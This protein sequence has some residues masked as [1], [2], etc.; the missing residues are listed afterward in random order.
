[1]F[2]AICGTTGRYTEAPG[3][4][5]FLE[6]FQLCVC[7]LHVVTAMSRHIVRDQLIRVS[8]EDTY[9]SLFLHT[10]GP[11]STSLSSIISA[12]VSV[13]ISISISEVWISM[14]VSDICRNILVFGSDFFR[15]SD[16]VSAVVA[17]QHIIVN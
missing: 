3:R 4:T 15:L 17:V 16:L 6:R 7:Y 10:L 8:I 5:T 1:M 11:S 9:F 13:I 12:C 2:E 14:T